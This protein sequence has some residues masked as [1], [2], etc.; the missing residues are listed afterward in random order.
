M[1][2]NKRGERVQEKVAAKA[3]GKSAQWCRSPPFP[4][5]QVVLAVV[6]PCRGVAMAR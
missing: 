1:I 4:A 3:S 2:V 5:S 6:E